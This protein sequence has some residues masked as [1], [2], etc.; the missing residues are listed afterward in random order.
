M[1]TGWYTTIHVALPF[2][3]L[4]LRCTCYFALAFLP[5]GGVFAFFLC[6]ASNSARF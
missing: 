6:D 1:I 3:V 2:R 4:V 5:S